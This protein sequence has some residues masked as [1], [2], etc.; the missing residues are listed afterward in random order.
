MS[1]LQQLRFVQG[2][3]AKKNFIA[4]MTHFCIQGGHVR[5]FNGKMALGSPIDFNIDCV[6]RADQLVQAIGNCNETVSLSMTPAG[7][8]AVR[9]GKFKAFVECTTEATPHVQPEG[10]EVPLD[11]A[12][13]LKAFET[14]MPFIGDDASRPWATGVLL[15]EESAYATNNVMICQYWLRAKIPRVVNVPREAIKEMLRIGEPPTHAQLTDFSMSFH[16][17][18]NRWLRTQLLD[19]KWPDMGKILDVQSSPQPIDPKLFEGLEML[20]PF[21]D[22]F[23]RVHMREGKLS[24]HTL[25]TEGAS[26]DVPEL[27]T[28]GC[29]ALEMLRLLEGVANSI[30]WTAYPKPCMFFGD[31]LRGALIGLRI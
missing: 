26:F 23:G 22:K 30:D 6:P 4:A 3:V 11:G 18:G 7:R 29:Y 2:A 1:M 25:D 28:E 19:V 12:A 15:Q 5:S 9:S 27:T 17:T 21:A 14:L 10:E 8:L 24:T 20:R 31:N 16:Y 13:M